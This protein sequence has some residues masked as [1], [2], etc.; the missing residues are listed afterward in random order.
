VLE[1]LMRDFLGGLTGGVDNSAAAMAQK[2]LDQAFATDDSDQRVTLAQK[3][4]EVS[5]DCADAY[6]LLAENA[7]SRKEALEL[8]QK[9]VEAGTRALGP[10]MYQEAAGSFW[11]VL[12][13]RPLMRA[14]LGMAETLW[15][16][17][18]RAEAVDQMQDMLR[19]N[20]SDNQGVRYTLCAWLLELD[21]DHDLAHLFNQ[22]PE[23]ETAAWAYYQTLLSYRRHGDTPETRAMLSQARK[24]NRHVPAFLL[25]NEPLPREQPATYA[26]GSR[27]EAIIYATTSLAAWKATPGGLTW[28]RVQE[29]GPPRSRPRA[30]RA[31]GPTHKVKQRLQQL[32]QEFDV[33]QADCRQLRHLVEVAD[34]P[35]RPWVVLVTSRSN[36]L[37]LSHQLSVEEPVPAQLWDG[38]ATAM[39]KPARGKP[40]RPSAVEFRPDGPVESLTPDIAALGIQC[41]ATGELEHLER[42]LDSLAEHL[43][44][45][46][47]PGLL[48]MP[49]VGPSQVAGFYHAAASF[50]RRAP[51]RSLGF[52]EAIKVECG[53]FQSG[54]W[55]SVV[56]GQSGLTTGLALYD[57]LDVLRRLWSSDLSDEENARETVALTVTFDMECDT[58]ISDQEAFRRHGW[59]VAGPEAHP[60][61]FRKERGISIRPPLAWELQL[62][63]GCL[64]ALPRFIAHHQSG[65]VES[66]P[67]TVPTSTG[68]LDLVL[69]WI[70]Q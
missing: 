26:A 29:K 70:E 27:R 9:G 25:G 64:R 60:T 34:E 43:G 42:V 6:V 11:G 23:E 45:S 49:G 57:D 66:H 24:Q 35:V 53:Q 16:L 63:E 15:T 44:G 67:V 14:K 46:G 5:A 19:L 40:H 20:P 54:P 30:V 37:V 62:M 7:A 17:G 28:L 51:W 32:P 8:Y 2:I 1:S 59:E 21:R 31:E 3:A 10:E 47:P 41:Q 33:W 13:T 39:K 58:P 65:D 50:Y 56:M 4:L 12:E 36:D 38:L 18:R 55:Y 48:D 68:R 69:S 22:F 52:E 61:I